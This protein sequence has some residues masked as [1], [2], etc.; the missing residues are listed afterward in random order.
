MNLKNEPLGFCIVVLIFGI[1]APVFS[2]VCGGSVRRINLVY[3][4]GVRPPSIVHYDLFYLM[5]RGESRVEYE[6]QAQFISEFL[7]GDRD[8]R[9]GRFWVTYNQGTKFL[10]ASADKAEAYI[11]G[12]N[13]AEFA[14]IA[15]AG[16]GGQL[17]GTT[18]DGKVIFRTRE[19]DDTTFIL[20][21]SANGFKTS[22]FVSNFLGGCFRG[23]P[24]HVIEMESAVITS[25][26]K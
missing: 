21:L 15:D 1:V 7:Y 19:M 13:A 17:S 2:Q 20:R 4:A 22:Y 3:A 12:Y 9:K 5:P 8:A 26:Q 23:K 14:R 11:N 10:P 25:T 16:H 18:S 24:P 6:E